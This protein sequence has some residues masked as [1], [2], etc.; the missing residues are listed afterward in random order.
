VRERRPTLEYLPMDAPE[1]ADQIVSG[2]FDLEG[3]SRW[4]SSSAAMT[5]KNPAAPMSLRAEFYIPPNAPARTVAL[6]LDGK[7]V[8]SKTYP[9][10]GSWSLESKPVR[11]E[12]DF[13]VVE[14]TV[15]K[16]FQS[17]PDTR[18]LGVVLMGVGFGGK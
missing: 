16:T 7:V 4:I 5:L 17:P 9:G 6:L 18:E 15:D 8:A 11:G 3:K 14:I 10:L 13:A 2:V 12:S 1:A